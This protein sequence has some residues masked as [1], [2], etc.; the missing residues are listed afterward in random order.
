MNMPGANYEPRLMQGSNHLQMRNDSEMG[1][2]V[3]AIFFGGLNRDYFKTD[4][5]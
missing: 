5:R 4:F 1:K 3:D 2:A